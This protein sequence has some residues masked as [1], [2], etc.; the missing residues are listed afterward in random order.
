MLN[1]TV[2]LGITV[3]DAAMKQYANATPANAL[4]VQ[5]DEW[6]VIPWGIPK[7]RIIPANAALSNS[8]QMRLWMG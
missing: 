6:K 4:G 7:Q 8:V 1:K 3:T 2:A 5:H